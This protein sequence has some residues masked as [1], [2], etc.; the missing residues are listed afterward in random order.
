MGGLRVAVRT[1]E[2]EVLAG[3]GSLDF[4]TR[5]RAETQDFDPVVSF[6]GDILFTER[7]CKRTTCAGIGGVPHAVHYQFVLEHHDFIGYNRL[8]EVNNTCPK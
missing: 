8:E 3:G 4:L 1:L 7:W 5:A 2:L 6:N